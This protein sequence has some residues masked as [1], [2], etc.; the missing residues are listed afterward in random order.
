MVTAEGLASAAPSFLSLMRS[1]LHSFN[2]S[3]FVVQLNILSTFVRKSVA[4]PAVSK[5]YSRKDLQDITQRLVESCFMIAGKS[6]NAIAAAYPVSSVAAEPREQ[7]FS[8]L[9]SQLSQS[10]LT[11]QRPVSPPTVPAPASPD[12][13]PEQTEQ[14]TSQPP[15]PSQPPTTP[16]ASP[17][18]QT[19]LSPPTTQESALRTRTPSDPPVL[20]EGPPT[21]QSQRSFDLNTREQLKRE[22]SVMKSNVSR[23]ALA[24]LAEQ[25][26]PLLDIVFSDDRERI[27]QMLVSS[28][29]HIMPYLRN[30]T[31][32][33][34]SPDHTHC[35]MTLLASIS[36]FSYTLRAWRKD[37]WDLFNDAEFFKVET[38]TIMKATKVVNQLMVLD[39]TAF[40]G[41]L[42]SYF[43]ISYIFI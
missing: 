34:S 31:N 24:Q 25:M 19:A 17:Q 33:G 37:V 8:P 42:F 1:A 35:A 2:P 5:K 6:F 10:S 9:T 41:N 12:A 38:R 27:I 4:N 20:Q 16:V 28:L 29:H 23:K 11:V 14:Q 32:S 18:A 30:R 3:S 40:S 43:S 21:L 13:P 36:E 15:S 7:T 22:A 26:A 39:R